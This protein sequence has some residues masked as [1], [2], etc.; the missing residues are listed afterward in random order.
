MCNQSQCSL[1]DT[2]NVKQTQM[3]CSKRYGSLFETE[4]YCSKTDLGTVKRGEHI[5][6]EQMRACLRTVLDRMP[7]SE[8]A[9]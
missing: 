3:G 8:T 2:K 7:G 9:S 4:K 1:I 5:G 6:Q